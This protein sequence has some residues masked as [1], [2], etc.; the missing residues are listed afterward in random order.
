MPGTGGTADRDQENVIIGYVTDDPLLDDGAISLPLWGY[1][2][3]GDGSNATDNENDTDIG[4]DA[5]TDEQANEDDHEDAHEKEEPNTRSMGATNSSEAVQDTKFY[6]TSN[7]GENMI[8]S[9]ISSS[10]CVKINRKFYF[11]LFSLLNF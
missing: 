8:P 5:E 11:H 4:P 2:T 3:A 10:F 1:M 9:S 6:K 7:I